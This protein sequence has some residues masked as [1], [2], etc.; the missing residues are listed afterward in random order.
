MMPAPQA[1][2]DYR[3]VIPA[4]PNANPAMDRPEVKDDLPKKSSPG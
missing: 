3:R 4:G 2:V 1:P